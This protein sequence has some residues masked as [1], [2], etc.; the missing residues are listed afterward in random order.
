MDPNGTPGGATRT[1]DATHAPGRPSD[2]RSGAT[3]LRSTAHR[4]P[5]W[6]YLWGRLAS[7]LPWPR[8]GLG[9]AVLLGALLLMRQPIADWLWPQTRAQQLHDQAA[10]ALAAGRLTATDGSGARELYEAALALDPD[11]GDARDG[12]NRVGQAALAQA[13]AA[14]GKQQYAIARNRLE[15]ATALSMPRRRIDELSER[16]RTQEAG[17]AGLDRLVAQAAAARAAGH[18]DDGPDAALPLYLRVLALQPDRLQA[19][20]GREDTLADLLQVAQDTLD[21]GD[22]AAAA[23]I[24][25][26]VQSADPGHVGLPDVLERRAGLVERERA[27]A[28]SALD[29][30]RLDAA[31]DGFQSLRALEPG[32]AAAERGLGAVAIAHARASERQAAD[33]NFD[34]AAASLRQARQVAALL[35]QEPPAIAHAQQHLARARQSQQSLAAAPA[36]KGRDRRVSELLL[37]AERA[38]A[39]GDLI[40]PP[41]DSAFDHLRMA[42]ALAPQDRRVRAAVA[43]LVPAAATCFEEALG[44][45]RLGRAGACLDARRA[46]EGDTAAVRE[47]RRELA[48]RW[49]AR[50]DER[51][52]AGEVEQARAALASARALDP[53][54]PEMEA[55]ARRL[56]AA[57]LAGGQID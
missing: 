4:A 3:R 26:R 36:G 40:T 22:Y 23:A 51:L 31:R 6:R 45:N 34:A 9:A 21:A 50:G 35:E 8:I 52:G 13:A 19:L 25:T 28:Q 43:R 57:T 41:G 17:G 49:I 27:R 30:G 11:Q 37:A 39:R 55:L 2:A 29:A 5:G 7:H 48:R 38:Q 44:N 42:N 54:A 47:G 16:L 10:Q 15:L 14:L 24:I 12:L 18:L 33:F 53:R 32:N 46:L 20:E 1:P 56:R